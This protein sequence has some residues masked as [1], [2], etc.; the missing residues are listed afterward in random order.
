MVKGD[1]DSTVA[2]TSIVRTKVYYLESG[3]VGE[4]RRVFR[5]D[6]EGTKGSAR[7]GKSFPASLATKG[8]G[9]RGCRISEVCLKEYIQGP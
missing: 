8:F 2:S 3:K 1:D 5:N 7:Y 6:R 9:E 4:V